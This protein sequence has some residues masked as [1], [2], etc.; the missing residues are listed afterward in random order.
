MIIPIDKE[1]RINSDRYQW[2]VQKYGGVNK[3]GEEV[4]RSETFHATLGHAVKAL[5]ERLCRELPTVGIEEAIAGVHEVANR[6]QQAL[7]SLDIGVQGLIS[8]QEKEIS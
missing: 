5:G 4:W 7:P 1:F 3:D 6:L 2:I 8:V